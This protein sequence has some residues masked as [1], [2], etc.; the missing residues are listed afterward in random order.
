[1][2]SAPRAMAAGA[3]LE[4]NAILSMTGAGSF[5]G[6]AENQ[7]LQIV[8]GMVN[9]SGGIRGRPLKFVVL[10][11]GSSPQTSVQLM[12]QL[13]AKRV[14]VVLGPAL[15]ASCAAVEPLA[16]AAGPLTYCLSPVV[17]P[18]PGSYLYSSSIGTKDFLPRTMQ[19]LHE[20]KLTKI[21]IFTSTDAT[22]QD[23]EKQLDSSL[24]LPENRD[25][26]VVA[27][28]HFAP[29]DL[30]VAAQMARIKA[31][32]PLAL[33]TFATGTPFGTV[34]RGFHDAGLDIPVFASAGNL[35]RVQ[36][37]QYAS[38]APSQL[39]FVAA[40]GAARDPSATGAARAADAAYF[41]GFTTAGIAPQYLNLYMW[42]PAM[43]V[44]E[45]LRNAGPDATAAQLR[46][47]L[48]RVHGR[49]GLF[50]TYDFG[51]HP[52]RGL[53]AESSTVYLWNSTAGE[54]IPQK[55][56]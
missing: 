2:L 41:D 48:A 34:L 36:L 50:G 31:A 24:A 10:D 53:G 56:P 33:M 6:S 5:L 4:V 55:Q 35:S 1:M 40:R 8:E 16:E 54:A 47:Y 43:L 29:A 3:P 46:S 18:A 13:V 49:A 32:V 44:V 22:G 51:K 20:H 21:A 12:N 17:E 42:D 23:Y 30:T 11:D 52:Q 14:P 45:A 27:R 15:T 39:L 7:S 37:Q 19:W 25:I 26:A 28:E 9:A 38:F